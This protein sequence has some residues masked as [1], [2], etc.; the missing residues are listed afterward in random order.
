MEGKEREENGHQENGMKQKDDGRKRWKESCPFS[1]TQVK[2]WPL[3]TNW[4][5]I[6]S[7][8]GAGLC[9][10]GGSTFTEALRGQVGNVFCGDLNC[11]LLCVCDLRAGEEK[12][13]Q[14]NLS[15]LFHLRKL[16]K[17]KKKISRKKIFFVIFFKIKQWFFMFSPPKR[18]F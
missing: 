1:R 4:S 7:P 2:Q 16:E 18:N 6:H 15:F 3:G 5:C 11:F 12:F 9:C 8:L 17:R 10:R 14:D 13:C